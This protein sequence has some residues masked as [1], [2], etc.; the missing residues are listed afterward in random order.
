LNLK[1][2]TVRSVNCLKIFV[3]PEDFCYCFPVHSLVRVREIT[4]KGRREHF[5]IITEILACA[6][7]GALKTQ[8]MYKARLS[9]AQL[10]SYLSMLV[11]PRLLKLVPVGKLL[12][13]KQLERERVSWK[14]T[15]N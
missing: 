9:Y 4:R 7:D 14:G 12:F 6:V 3:I 11:K 1:N 10:E 8:L 15:R 13:M 2:E 5:R